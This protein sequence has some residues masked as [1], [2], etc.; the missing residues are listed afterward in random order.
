MSVVRINVIEIPEGRGEELERRFAN[1]AGAVDRA[2]G[3]LGFELLRPTGWRDQLFRIHPLGVRRCL[4]GLAFECCIRQRAR[5]THGRG[6]GRH[7][8]RPAQLRRRHRVERRSAGQRGDHRLAVGLERGVGIVMHQVEG[9]L[10]HPETA[11]FL[12]LLDVPVRRAKDAEP[13]DDVVGDEIRTR[14]AR[15]AMMGVVV[16]LSPSDVRGEGARGPC[17]RRPYRLTRSTTWLP[18]IPPNQRSCSRWCA[19]SSRRTPAPPRRW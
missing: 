17:S 11:E 10:V 1:R 13:V 16:L 7:R 15:S 5:P 18:T 8:L 4:R 14:V 2:P 6:S 12:E 19:T 3:F 9:E